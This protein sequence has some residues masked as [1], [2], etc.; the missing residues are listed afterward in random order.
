MKGY[1]RRDAIDMATYSQHKVRYT[2]FI[3]NIKYLVYNV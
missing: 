1:G 2:F 3:C